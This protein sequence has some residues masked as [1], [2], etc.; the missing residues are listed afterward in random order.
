MATDS[1]TGSTTSIS[2]KTFLKPSTT[3]FQWCSRRL[4]NTCE[5]ENEAGTVVGGNNL[6]AAGS[7]H[8][9]KD[10]TPP[11]PTLFMDAHAKILVSYEYTRH[12]NQTIMLG[13]YST[14]NL[15]TGGGSPPHSPWDFGISEF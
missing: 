6:L 7:W 4:T 10:V 9:W 1:P 11:R 13:P 2:M 14:F 12:G 3:P 15:E 5:M 8:G